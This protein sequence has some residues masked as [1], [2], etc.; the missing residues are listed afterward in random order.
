MLKIYTVTFNDGGWH[1]S[2]PKKTIVASSKSEAILKA[3]EDNKHYDGWDVWASEFSLEGYV[4]E[5][6]DEKSYV[7]DK[8][9]ET[10][11]I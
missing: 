8:K 6:Y 7:R 1:E 3:K 10:I 9:L 4:I 5:V 11:N 2:L